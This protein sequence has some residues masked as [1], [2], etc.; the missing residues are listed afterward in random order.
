VYRYGYEI[1]NALVTDLQPD[2][3]VLAAMNQIEAQR[4]MR[5]AATERAEGEKI[6]VVKAAEADAESKF[7]SGEGVARQ[8][9]A[10]VEGL[11]ESVVG[12]NEGVVGT[13]PADVMQLMMVT[14]YLDM[15][16]D[17]GMNSKSTVF[18]PHT[19]GAVT[20][21]QSQMRQGFL[22]ANATAN[23]QVRPTM[24]AHAP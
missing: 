12:F 17:V 6:L 4:R 23:S 14:Q 21:V 1:V 10:I 5:M 19:P 13:S 16:K 9:K 24:A 7:L 11:K 22:E 2:G 15:M 8:R 20:D 3:Q 18:I